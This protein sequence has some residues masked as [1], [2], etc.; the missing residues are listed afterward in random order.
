MP[1]ERES[2]LYGL[3]LFYFT[4]T[5][6][7][8]SHPLPTPGV[9]SHS[10]Q[11]LHIAHLPVCHPLPIA[12]CSLPC[13]PLKREKSVEDG[14]EEEMKGSRKDISVT[15]T[16]IGIVIS[17]VIGIVIGTRF[18]LSIAKTSSHPPSSDSYQGARDAAGI[19]ITYCSPSMAAKKKKKRERGRTEQNRTT[20]R[21]RGDQSTCN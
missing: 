8:A 5:P 17:I 21:L 12:H 11:C 10:I 13:K 4:P 1:V 2:L 18:P 19:I 20:L 7:F 6:Y 15:V 3:I 9:F 14:G 16:V